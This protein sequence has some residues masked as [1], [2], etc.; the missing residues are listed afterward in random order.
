MPKRDLKAY[1][2]RRAKRRKEDKERI[3][4]EKEKNP[5]FMTYRTKQKLVKNA[6]LKLENS[7]VEAIE[8][9]EAL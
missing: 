1:Y 7:L 6:K 4:R 3:Q 2:E 9:L 5:V 8:K